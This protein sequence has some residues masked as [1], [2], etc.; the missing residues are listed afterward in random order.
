MAITVKFEKGGLE[1][2][3][4]MHPAALSANFTYNPNEDRKDHHYSSEEEAKAEAELYDHLVTVGSMNGL[5]A[6]DFTHLF[7]A[8]LRML[9]SNSPW[10]K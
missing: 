7:P 1:T 3:Q 10:A 2:Y 6:N 4:P 8:V 5:T 9:K